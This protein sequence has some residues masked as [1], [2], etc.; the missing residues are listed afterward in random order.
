[1]QNDN[2]TPI[3]IVQTPQVKSDQAIVGILLCEQRE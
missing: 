1:L 3:P 2:G